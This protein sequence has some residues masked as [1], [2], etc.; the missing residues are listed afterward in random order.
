MTELADLVGL[1]PARVVFLLS[2][3]RERGQTVATAESLTG[4]LLT[5]LLTAVPGASTV[6]RGGIICYATDLKHTL[7]G[8]DV[9]LLAARGPVDPDVARQL[10]AGV[11]RRCGASIGVALTGVAGPDPQDGVPVGAVYVAI[12]ADGATTVVGPG[13]PPAGAGR[14]GVRAAAVRAAVELLATAAGTIR[15]P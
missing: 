10:A 1:D 8:V 15:R 3:L 9:G 12:D 5:A 4:G 7:V 14:W 13:L 2:E 11:R 6:V